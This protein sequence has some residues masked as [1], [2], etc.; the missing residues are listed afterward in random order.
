MS[1]PSHAFFGPAFPRGGGRPA[2][3]H[4]ARGT[5]QPSIVL[6]FAL[7]A[8]SEAMVSVLDLDGRV[9]R[10]L[11]REVLAAGEH[12]CAWDGRDERGQ[13]L[14]PGEYR[15]QLDSQGRTLTSRVVSIR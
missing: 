7:P 10:V 8:A 4:V 15:I 11:R 5:P 13:R 14:P 6:R 2:A 9:V 3:P 1:R 12:L